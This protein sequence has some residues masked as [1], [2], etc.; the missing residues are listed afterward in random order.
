MKS[1]AQAT[2]E[3]ALAVRE[4]AT[5]AETFV[6]Q[7]I[8]SQRLRNMGGLYARALK[9]LLA[10]AR[11]FAAKSDEAW[12]AEVAELRA[13]LRRVYEYHQQSRACE[14]RRAVTS[15]RPST[16]CVCPEFDTTRK[17]LAD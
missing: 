4:L 11:R 9:A 1:H 2:I 7:R 15:A 3:E 13:E 8:R 5:Q 12:A 6:A 10:A 16:E 14:D 17:L